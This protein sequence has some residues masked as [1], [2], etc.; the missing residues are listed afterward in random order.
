MNRREFVAG[1]AA[2][3]AA[4]ARLG[5]HSIGACTAIA[6]YSLDQAIQL[7]RALALPVIELHPMGVPEAT[8]GRF[9]GFEFD[10]LAETERRRLRESLRGFRAVTSHLPYSG[11]NYFAKGPAARE[12]VR[13]V[14]AALEAT[15]Y[16]GAKLAVLHPMPPQG[17]EPAAGW[18]AM[19]KR[20][21]DWGDEALRGRFRLGLE[22]G[23]PPSVRDFVRLVK[24]VDHPAVGATIDVGHQAN[25]AELA[26]KVKPG[27]RG[28]PAGIR[29]YN[30]TT[31]AIIEQLGAKVFHLHVHDIEPATWKEHKPFGSGFVD[32]PRLIAALRN[33]GYAGCLV[34]EIG[35]PPD[36]MERHL[37]DGK[38]RLE[39]AL[40]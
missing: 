31:I 18:S 27:E 10:R 35:A 7:L 29:A 14:E 11:L 23:Y 20:I 6:G 33:S 40:A 19:V 12:S 9:P 22:T 13:A 17:F 15:A 24:E 38:R 32:Y 36:E 39:A 37:R 21:R 30:D 1:F 34:M 2:G 28:T 26:A 4:P 5:P 16:F 3:W 25:Y 8:P